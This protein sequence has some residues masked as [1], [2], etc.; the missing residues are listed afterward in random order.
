[1]ATLVMPFPIFLGLVMLGALLLA[2]GRRRAGLRIVLGGVFFLVLA[3]WWP[4]AEGLLAPLENRYPPVTDLAALDGVTAVVVLG[5]GWRPK[6]GWPIS[7]QL[8]ESS[9]IR[10]FEGL[11]L[12]R[13][14]PEARLI[15]SGGSRR[16]DRAPV[17]QG[18]AQA[19]RELGV[20][21][22]RILTLDTP[23]D[24]AQEAYAVKAA[25]GTEP[26]FVLVTS[27]AHMPRA[28][29]H[30]QRVGLDPIP[31]PTE[32]LTGRSKRNSL[33][34]WLPSSGDLDKTGRAWHE[35]LGLLALGLEY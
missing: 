11:R 18:Y 12:L 6:P 8:N 31:A 3:S 2:L 9:A 23:L 21:A 33:L 34:S 1:M 27:A 26:R 20:P 14:L 22:A 5:G 13:A 29:R 7:S 19:A 30:F 15:V 17:A 4:V 35:Y 25:L 28:V 16:A 24:T 32:H 10:L